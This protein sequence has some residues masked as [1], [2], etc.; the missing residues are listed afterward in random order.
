MMQGISDCCRRCE[1][2]YPACHDYCEKY[3]E[4]LEKWNDRKAKI[5]A[6]KHDE[7]ELYKSKA[8]LDMKRRRRNG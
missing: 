2:R 7:Y 8:I 4:A 1:E 5:K 3:Q 6:E